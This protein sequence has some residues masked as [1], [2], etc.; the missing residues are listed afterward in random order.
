MKISSSPGGQVPKERLFEA[1]RFYTKAQW[2][3]TNRFSAENGWVSF[4]SAGT[5]WHFLN[6]HHHSSSLSVSHLFMCIHEVSKL[7]VMRITENLN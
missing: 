5:T 4:V 1:H 6:H 2:E 7:K 3:P